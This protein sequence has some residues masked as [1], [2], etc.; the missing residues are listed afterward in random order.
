V[1][2]SAIYVV[3]SPVLIPIDVAQGKT[4]RPIV[5]PSDSAAVAIAPDGR[6]A[7]VTTAASVTPIDLA[8]GAARKAFAVPR[9]SLL[10]V[11]GHD[12]RTGYLIDGSYIDVLNLRRGGMVERRI[13]ARG[14]AIDSLLLPA[15]GRS[16]C[17][18][19]ATITSSG[20]SE[21]QEPERV[22]IVSGRTGKLVKVPS[23]F[24]AAL[25]PDGRTAYI[26]T[27]N[28]LVPVDLATGKVGRAIRMPMLGIG[29]IAITA[30]GRTAYV[31]SLKPPGP[32]SG[33]VVPVDLATGTV[34]AAIHVPS[35]P[36]SITDIV[37]ARDQRTAY[38]AAY[39]SV[40]P[41]NLATSRPEPPIRMPGGAHAIILA[42]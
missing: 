37:I 23:M 35:Y 19:G 41:I 27:G 34:H 7:Y 21:Q 18:I 11:V 28:L 6:T 42:P 1:G 24:A 26:A 38:V 17:I 36:Y 8:S 33:V 9:D 25:S 30:N 20:P 12:N 10:M 16:G 3:D 40:I 39:S 2:A 4:G 22:D 32:H 5:L 31:G 13:V 14:L 29:A 15:T